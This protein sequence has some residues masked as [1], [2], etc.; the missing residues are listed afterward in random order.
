MIETR[1]CW[2]PHCSVQWMKNDRM[3]VRERRCSGV[4]EIQCLALLLACPSCAPLSSLSLSLSPSAVQSGDTAVMQA[5]MNVF[6]LLSSYVSWP[7]SHPSRL[8]DLPSDLNVS[9]R[10]N[11]FVLVEITLSP[12][13]VLCK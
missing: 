1:G 9:R 6:Q 4:V 12:T 13:R 5:G 2:L 10:W 7:L 3:N 8:A 11:G